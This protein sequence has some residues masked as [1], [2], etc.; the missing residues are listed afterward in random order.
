M[1]ISRLVESLGYRY[2]QSEILR[3]ALTHRSYSPQHNERLEFLGDSVIN[4]AI[5]NELY[6]K[7][8]SLEEGSLSRLRALLVNQSSL[9]SIASDLDLGSCL[10]LGEGELK[11][12][13]NYRPSIL[14]DALE[15]VVGAVFVDGGFP[16][17]QTVVRRI[18]KGALDAIDPENSGKDAKTQLQE[19]LQSRRLPLPQYD[20][21]AIH[22]EAHQ[23]NFEVTCIIS[24]LNI[25]GLG[26]GTSR[27]RAEQEAA[28]QA[29]ELAV[30]V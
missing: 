15:A 9:A 5:A 26:R 3:Q 17:V 14:A 10:L 4:C 18:F 28:R 2:G 20:V 30:S 25:H 8:P 13:G 27:R 29:Y 22:G 23:Q 21:V 16:A 24:T 6:K 7:Y 1:N 12:G 11:S 19:L